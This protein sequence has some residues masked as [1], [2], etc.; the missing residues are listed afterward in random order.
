M[1]KTLIALAVAASAVSGMAHAWTNG[2]FNGSVD[3]GG[4]ITADDYRQKWEWMSGADLSYTNILNELKENGTRLTINQPTNAPIL[5]GRTTEAFAAPVTSGV[6]AIPLISFSDYQG[7]SVS[8]EYTDVE[9]Q[10][11]GMITLPVKGNDGSNEV[12]GRAVVNVSAAGVFGR[13]G[14]SQ[15]D[16]TLRSLLNGSSNVT[17]FHGG[18]LDSNRGLNTGN[19]A[20]AAVAKFGGLS[21]GGILAQIQAVYP[22]V[23]D[24]P[25]S[26]LNR[27]QENMYYD[28]G[29][30]VSASYALGIATGQKIDVTFNNPV[31]KSTQWSAPLN[32]AVTYN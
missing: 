16:N 22:N 24:L 3:I 27:K 32:M 13:A 12:I 8:L 9:R 2:D 6:G 23:T 15:H 10:G 5:V 21:A 11:V 25:G 1:K 30:V 4:S 29:S 26:D 7:N 20:A 31:T 17:I 19:D 28:D 18:L 14:G